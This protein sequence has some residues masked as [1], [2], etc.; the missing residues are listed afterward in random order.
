MQVARELNYATDLPGNVPNSIVLKFTNRMAT[1]HQG[2]D[3]ISQTGRQTD[4]QTDRHSSYFILST[5]FVFL[6]ILAVDLLFLMF[7]YV[8][9]THTHDF[10]PT[11]TPTLHDFLPTTHDPRP[12]VKLR[13]FFQRHS[14]GLSPRT[15]SKTSIFSCIITANTIKPLVARSTNTFV[16]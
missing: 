12:L 15:Y 3:K 14:T 4:R 9:F 11:P 2:C 7:N 13:K 6:S 10:L 5:C 16:I 8:I 1:G